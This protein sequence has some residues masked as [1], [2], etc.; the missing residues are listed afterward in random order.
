MKKTPVERAPRKPSASARTRSTPKRAAR[1]R[2]KPEEAAKEILDAAER[3]LRAR[4]FRDLQVW[5]LMD[6]TGLTRSSFYHYFVDRH[7]LMMR[8]IERLTLELSPMNEVWFRGGGD[9]VTNLREGYE[10]VGQFWSQHGPVLRAIADAA[11]H[12]R[13]VEKAY[14][15]FV[16][17]FVRMTAARIRTDIAAGL[18]PPLEADETAKA[19]ILMSERYLNEHLGK[20]TPRDWRPVVEIL[21]TIWQRALYGETR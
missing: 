10:G 11:T 3:F 1:R 8:L 5:N 21:V 4:P 7:E 16:D 12:D 6:Q 18:I 13:K 2:R 9:P 17:R 14:R 20:R 15:A 19:L